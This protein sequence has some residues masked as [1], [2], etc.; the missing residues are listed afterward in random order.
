M[1]AIHLVSK[2]YPKALEVLT[3]KNAWIWWKIPI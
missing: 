3:R 1:I 2:K